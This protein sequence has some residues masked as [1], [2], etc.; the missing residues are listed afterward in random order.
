MFR[1]IVSLS[2]VW[3]A[4]CGV[5]LAADPP[6]VWLDVPFVKQEKDGCG[7]ASIAMVM[8]Y[9]RTQQGQPPNDT[10][11]ASQIQRALYSANAHGIYA[12]DMERYFRENDFRTFT[13]RGEWEDLKQHLSKGRPLIVALK[14]ASGSAFHY[15]VVTGIGA[16]MVMINDPAQRKL[17]QQD[18]PSFE[19]EWSA[20]GNWTLLALPQ[21]QSR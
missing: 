1:R 10:S 2:V 19:R 13:I 5:L 3:L 21:T 18:R 8:Q 6:G 20:A 12:S 16:E 7:A 9:W 17:L 4:V 14:P 11:D 15:V